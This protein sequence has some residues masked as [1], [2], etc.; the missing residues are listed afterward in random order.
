MKNVIE[1]NYQ[2]AHEFVNKNKRNGFFW[3]GWTIVKW[4]PGHNG[5]LQTN[6]MY[7]KGK[8]GFAFRYKL[9][10]KGTW[11]IPTKYVTNT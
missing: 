1:L 6:G 2:Q 3:D 4:I 11:V 8:W 10:S 7:R 5:Y 9:N